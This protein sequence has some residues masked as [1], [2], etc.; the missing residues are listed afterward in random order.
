MNNVSLSVKELTAHKLYAVGWEPIT[1]LFIPVVK[2]FWKKSACLRT[3][4]LQR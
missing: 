4:K 2:T 3:S 1:I